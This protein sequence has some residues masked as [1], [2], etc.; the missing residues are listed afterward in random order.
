MAHRISLRCENVC[1]EARKGMVSISRKS[2]HKLVALLHVR[3]FLYVC[4]H[5]DLQHRSY[6]LAVGCRPVDESESVRVACL[7]EVGVV[8]AE[9]V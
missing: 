1:T 7:H 9:D 4:V 6:A 2:T 5:V 8:V 3:V